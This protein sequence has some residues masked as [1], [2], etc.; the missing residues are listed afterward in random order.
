MQ[1]GAVPEAVLDL[2]EFLGC[3]AAACHGGCLLHALES[4]SAQQLGRIAEECRC[5]LRERGQEQIHAL[6][7]E[8]E[9]LK[10]RSD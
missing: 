8:D 1:A 10:L 5:V 6:G 7:V 3:R 2:V 4:Y 9:L